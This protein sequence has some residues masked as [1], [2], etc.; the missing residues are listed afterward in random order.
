MALLYCNTDPRAAT[1]YIEDVPLL[2]AMVMSI[3]LATDIFVILKRMDHGTE[4][5]KFLFVYPLTMIVLYLP[6]VIDSMVVWIY[7][8]DP[9]WLYFIHIVTARLGGFA[10]MII[11]GR[12]TITIVNRENEMKRQQSVSQTTP[13]FMLGPT[14]LT[15]SFDEL[16]KAA[17]LN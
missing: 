7:G 16:S 14:D 6:T 12:R 13:D 2:V 15:T 11:Y 5:Y 3:V 17:Q 1:L 10:N 9:F 4:E 8:E